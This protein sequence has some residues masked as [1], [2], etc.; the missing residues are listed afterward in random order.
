[1]AY[2]GC[3]RYGVKGDV[4][5]WV[6]KVQDEEVHFARPIIILSIYKEKFPEWYMHSNI[7]R[8]KWDGRMKKSFVIRSDAFTFPEC[9]KCHDGKTTCNCQYIKKLAK[10]NEAGAGW[11]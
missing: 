5:V 7:F 1:M 2:V 6:T 8:A 9:N 11:W 3:V 4:Q 10:R